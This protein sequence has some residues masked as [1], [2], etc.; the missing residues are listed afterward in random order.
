MSTRAPGG[1]L[2]AAA[3]WVVAGATLAA[4]AG[5]CSTPDA[6][7]AGGIASMGRVRSG[8]LLVLYPRGAAWGEPVARDVL[9]ILEQGRAVARD[10]VGLEDGAFAVALVES[11]D[12]GGE[13]YLRWEFHDARLD[14]VVTA[15]P[16]PVGPPGAVAAAVD[17]GGSVPTAESG[18]LARIRHLAVFLEV[19]ELAHVML[20]HT[21]GP[22]EFHLWM[23]EGVAEYVALRTGLRHHPADVTAFLRERHAELEDL[24]RSGTLDFLRW[25]PSSGGEMHAADTLPNGRVVEYGWS[26]VRDPL[27]VAGALRELRRVSAE[28]G[29]DV[30]KE[31]RERLW[32]EWLAVLESEPRDDEIEVDSDDR[33]RRWGVYA[34]LLAFFFEAGEQGGDEGLVPFVHDLTPLTTQ[35]YAVSHPTGIG[36]ATP[37]A[38]RPRLHATNDEVALALYKAT[39]SDEWATLMRAYPVRRARHVLREIARGL[40]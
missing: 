38:T 28:L 10:H 25:S 12:E 7:W 15:F 39:G 23:N 13:S 9:Q 34:A 21:L 32:S 16:L 37:I 1:N 11:A 20:E 33:S 31:R 29:D 4:L 27:Q 18:P 2:R 19:H 26:D 14:A 36:E 8:P 22:Q 30:D 3:A 35:T 5:G 40:K 17:A 24:G 6:S